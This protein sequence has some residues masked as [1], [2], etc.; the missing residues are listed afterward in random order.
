MRIKS[1]FIYK[2]I[3]VGVIYF[4]EGTMT[5]AQLPVPV[6]PNYQSSMPVNYI[7]T[8]EM[9]APE[10]NP[11]NVLNKPLKQVKQT[12]GYLDGLGRPLQTVVKQGSINSY[13]PSNQA[14]FTPVVADLIT[15]NR[16][17]EFGREQ[18]KILP[19]ASTNSGP[20]QSDGSFKYDPFRQQNDFYNQQ[21]AG[22]DGEVN[23]GPDNRNWT[24]SQTIF[25][26]SPLSRPVEAFSPGSSWIGTYGQALPENRKSVKTRYLL[27]TANDAV[28][29]WTVSDGVLPAF[30]NYSTSTT[31]LP[32]T[33]TKQISI[34]EHNNQVIEF[35]DKEGQLI[36]KKVQ[37]STAVNTADDGAGRGH[38]GW[39]CTYYIYDDLHLLRCVIQPKAVDYLNGA[40]W[41]AS[42][43]NNVLAELCFR[44]EY[45]GR[46]R[47][48]MKKVP[49]A[50]E[51]Y[52]VY[53]SK[54]RLVM[55]QDA[56]L[57][58]LNKWHV[59]LYDDLNRPVET[60]L[61]LNSW[62]GSTAKT[63]VQHLASA[64]PTPLPSSFIPYPFSAY[65]TP[66]V[67]HWEYL[68]K[69]GYDDYST[70]PA[71]SNLNADID[72]TNVNS[73][74]GFYESYNSA[75]D[76]AEAVSSTASG[77][78]KGLPTWYET[79]ILGT[80][81][82]T[83][84]VTLYDDKGRPIQIKTK[85]V[86]NG[87]DIETHQYNWAGKILVSL[88]KLEKAGATAQT[89]YI[90]SRN[91]YDD[92]GRLTKIDKKIQNT[93]VNNNELPEAYT[94]IN[95]LEYDALGQ[96][97]KKGIGENPD[98]PS[99]PLAKQEFEYNVRGW[100]M[101][102]NKGYLTSENN[103][104]EY[105]GLQ[106]GYDKNP[107][108]GTFIP[109]FNGNI[110]GTIWKSEGD[111]QLRKYDFTYDA[112]NR[113]LSADFN[114]FV[115]GSGSTASFN[116]SAGIDFSVGALAYD[117][118]GNI[119]R[120]QQYG[121][122][123]TTSSMVDDL[124]YTY[125]LN[126]N[127]LKNVVDFNNNVL[128]KLGDFKTLNTHPQNSSKSSLT[129][130]SP[131][132]IFSTI[133]DYTY[134]TNGSLQTDHNKGISS[135]TYNHLN[136]PSL[137][138]M[139]G[140][141]GSI[142]Y[143]YDAI[144]NKLKKI[145]KENNLTVP[146]NGV[147]NSTNVT[148]TTTYLSGLVYEAKEYS[149]AA[150]ASLGY[151]DKLQF[152]GHEE[153][154]VRLREL[155]NTLHY[156]YMLKDHLG[157]VR[158]VLTQEQ[159]TNFYPAATLEGSFSVSGA[160]Q[161]NSMVNHEKLYFKI[162]QDKITPESA[163]P[164]W[165]DPAESV[166]NTKLYYNNNGNPPANLSYPAGCL[167][168]QNVQSNNLYKLNALT[169]RTG[170]EFAIKVMAGD[171]VDIFG[172]SYFL[173]TS[174]VDNSNS[175]VLDLLSVMSGLIGAPTG[176]IATKGVTATQLSSLNLPIFPGSFF[177]GANGETS[178]TPKAYINYVF[179][180]EQFKFAGGGASRVRNSGLV[181]DH[182]T[183]DADLRNI[184]VPK[185]GYLF[186]Y[187][188]N[189]SNLDVFFDNL[190]VIHKPGPILE[191]THYYP[192]GLTMAGI[193]S[194]AATGLDNKYEF[195]GKEKQE[196]EF[197]DGSGLEWYDYGARMFD[198]QIGRW[199]VADPLADKMRRHSPYNYA[200]DNPIRF[201]DPDGMEAKDFVR[202]GNGKIY[203]DKNANS[204][205]TT[206]DGETY[207]GK[208]LTFAFNSYI[209]EKGWDGPNPPFGTA[210]GLK[211]SS[212]L[213]I[214]ATETADGSFYSAY[215]TSNTILGNTPIGK[216]RDFFPGLGDD[217]NKEVLLKNVG[218]F[219]ATFEQ[220]ASVSKIE[221]MAFD[222]LGFDVVNVA[223]KLN[224]QFGGN[225]LS[226][227]AETDVFPSAELT[228]NGV[229]LF[230]YD[231][232]SFLQTHTKN[233][234]LSEMGGVPTTDKSRRSPPAFFIRYNN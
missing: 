114:Q 5:S 28:R 131:E 123:S 181:T 200:F 203:W 63:F 196:K 87:T 3:L 209:S 7:R 136:L 141:K 48:I 60:G 57:R 126:T 138:N 182:W 12:T 148:V 233:L 23:V 4:T 72:L 36:L 161:D 188:S 13:N 234:N 191:E 143:Q 73:T 173:N 216:P 204:Q 111:Q 158:V 71:A 51:V 162:D 59:T 190:Q 108:T 197:S 89:T 83:Y 21:L 180:D 54:D 94:T 81:S 47:L 6:P 205:A 184:V 156:D 175:T 121:L 222:V 19:F 20:S 128:T 195:N 66:A 58:G 217:Q 75:P 52:N 61:L 109:S 151:T 86:T 124:K 193:S 117:L 107:V 230:K 139:K 90:V 185:N 16:Y 198:A 74:Y 92:L 189:E 2:A 146:Y 226:V 42:A 1:I 137:I 18:L 220:H 46:G 132:G 202:G 224:V 64:S 207:L 167:P 165:N 35:K 129:S 100:M 118:N 153:G 65:S 159:S 110:S 29:M 145:V 120:M 91:S 116:K 105:F 140:G 150:L 163:I 69:S 38:T 133:I 231:Q 208:N 187:V 8:W 160:A 206:K 49:G 164:S 178:T 210:A 103:N 77:F 213:T 155:D 112:S 88:Q 232:P 170:L 192:F 179:L 219:N 218:G 104:S 93:L 122:V 84:S 9:N 130:N 154:R 166:A 39:I 78:T 142:T 82:Y 168:D 228:V 174:T 98:A 171:K 225:E 199:Y 17:D 152:I 25:D 215:V 41:T 101:S 55:T 40:G 96:V 37:I 62:S 144:G 157:N 212:T 127:K 76:F 85:N 135:I 50:G 44:Y 43:V 11:A 176:G 56:F 10:S 134:N 113:L 183:E 27:N 177:R 34:D 115:S 106:L 70:L 169:N 30:G 14:G 31:Y 97:R 99:F 45:D 53:D 186:V 223:Q 125:Q 214:Q 95:K 102:V 32:G 79:K 172:K 33:L 201:V 211:L 80:S 22:Q 221:E 68:T 119:T 227:T 194:K 229:Q 67:A 26:G 24:Y 149:N 147:D 15:A